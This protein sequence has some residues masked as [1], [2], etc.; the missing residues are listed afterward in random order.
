[1]GERFTTAIKYK[2]YYAVFVGASAGERVRIN[3]FSSW[4]WSSGSRL[5]GYVFQDLLLPP[6]ARPLAISFLISTFPR[7]KSRATEAQICR[8][9]SYQVSSRPSWEKTR[10]SQNRGWGCVWLSTRSFSSLL[11]RTSLCWSPSPTC[12]PARHPLIL[13]PGRLSSVALH[14]LSGGCW[15]CPLNEEEHRIVKWKC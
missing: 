1:M 9:C 8:F 6:A 14:S 3:I 7:K 15:V 10:R 4:R 13:N 5:S 11:T 12:P 2:D